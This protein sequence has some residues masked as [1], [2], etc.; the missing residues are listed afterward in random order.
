MNNQEEKI[1]INMDLRAI[2]QS[3][4]L[5]EDQDKLIPKYQALADYCTTYL[6]ESD[7]TVEQRTYAQT[8]K[9]SCLLQIY[10]MTMSSDEKAKHANMW[11]RR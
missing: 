11:S 3:S 5:G 10:F 8:V 6:L 2:E 1:K 4:R 9:D 7:L